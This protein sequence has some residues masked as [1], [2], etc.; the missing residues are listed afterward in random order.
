M[1]A[2]WVVLFYCLLLCPKQV[3]TF[4]DDGGIKRESTDDGGIHPKGG[5]GNTRTTS[6]DEESSRSGGGDDLSPGKH[7]QMRTW[8]D[9]IDVNED[10]FATLEEIVDWILMNEEKGASAE[11]N[12]QWSVYD[13][14][15]DGGVSWSEY[16]LVLLRK[17]GVRDEDMNDSN[18]VDSFTT[19]DKERFVHAD[20]NKNDYLDREELKA[21]LY[22][23]R[24][25]HM[26][27]H[28][29]DQMLSVWDKDSSGEVTFEEYKDVYLE[30]FGD[31][32]TGEQANID[33]PK[34]LDEEVTKFQ[35]VYDKNKD[36]KLTRDEIASIVAPTLREDTETEAK[37]I[38]D[39]ADRDKDGKV[40]HKEMMESMDIFLS[41]MHHEG[42][43]GAHDEL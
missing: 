1:A 20:Q 2:A 5:V 41:E 16:Q 21:L 30:M 31:L 32:R 14:N 25:E 40:S 19:A 7:P 13:T 34:T 42:G 39:H 29:I 35:N 6:T 11:V 17:Y 10:G 23:H 18:L 9:D 33:V 26:V 28:M 38:L 24:H 12:M 4:E 37:R 15:N 22:P 36:G 3:S 27:Q 43:F 8:I